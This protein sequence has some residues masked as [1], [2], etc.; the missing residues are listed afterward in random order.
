MTKRRWGGN[1]KLIIGGLVAGVIILVIIVAVLINSASQKK[2][3]PYI[4]NTSSNQNSDST[5]KDGASTNTNDTATDPSGS[6]SQESSNNSSTPV[7]PQKVA[8]I[9]VTPLSL[10][11]SY[12][13]GVGGFEYQVLRTPGGTKYVEFKSSDLIGT[14]CTDDSGTFASI[15]VNPGSAESATLAKTVKVDGD[16]Y[17]LSLADGT[18]T[19][20]PDKLKAYQQS[21]SDAFSL[22]KK[23]S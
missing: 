6:S 19:S 5:T 13:K 12:I 14:K 8:T 22:L 20:S 16:T 11:V 1:K 7:D 9:D 15:L 2:T 23:S 17:G 18:C 21:F 3:D 4:A 10:T